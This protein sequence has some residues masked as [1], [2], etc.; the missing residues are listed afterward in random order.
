MTRLWHCYGCGYEA[1]LGPGVPGAV[2]WPCLS[3]G[4][5]TM[6]L[7]RPEKPAAERRVWIGV[8]MTPDAVRALEQVIGARVGYLREFE[9][10]TVQISLDVELDDEGGG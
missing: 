10:A 2:A 9:G 5:G 3:C 7:Q 4:D 1:D 8:P 6:T